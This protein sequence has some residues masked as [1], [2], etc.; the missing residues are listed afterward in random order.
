VAQSAAT[1]VEYGLDAPGVVA[2]LAA[3]GA[4]GIAL[5]VILYLLLQ[6]SSLTV[7]TILLVWAIIG[8][9]AAL[10]TAGFMVWSSKVG[11]LDQRDR[12]LDSLQWR[13]DEQVL[14][15]GC[16]HGLML[17]GAAKRL[18][19]S[20][21]IG[22]DLWRDADQAAN[23]PEA[24]MANARSE[25]VADRVEVRDGD[26]RQ[27]PFEDGTFDVVLSSLVIHNMRDKNDRDMAIR[28]IVRVLKPGGRLAV[29]DLTNTD[30]YAQLLK[31]SGQAN[32]SLSKPT[33]LFL[34]PT[35]VVRS[36]KPQ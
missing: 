9:G 35:R 21:A 15:V 34:F 33:F 16:G 32:V 6:G 20:K 27:L 29:W 11:K 1:K 12:I 3:G 36:T 30:E 18:T 14:D 17:I 13:G 7:A 10:F 4:G 19:T 5:G 24:T 22:V 31:E 8:G 25:G 28:E 23:S 2:G 26:A